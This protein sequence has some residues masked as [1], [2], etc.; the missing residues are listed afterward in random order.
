MTQ[1]QHITDI[2]SHDRRS[3]VEFRPGYHTLIVDDE[4]YE[5]GICIDYEEYYGGDLARYTYRN[6]P[7]EVI[8]EHDSRKVNAPYKITVERCD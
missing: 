8:V 7:Y 3:D 2:H 4:T 5:L 1:E 6:G